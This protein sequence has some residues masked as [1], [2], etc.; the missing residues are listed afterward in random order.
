VL[1]ALMLILLAIAFAGVVSY[2]HACADLTRG[3]GP[4][5]DKTL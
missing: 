5:Q 2:V 4:A 1:D 3:S